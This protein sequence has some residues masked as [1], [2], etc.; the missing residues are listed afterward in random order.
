MH[1]QLPFPKIQRQ[2]PGHLLLL[3]SFL[4]HMHQPVLTES[5]KRHHV[6]HLLRQNSLKVAV[7]LTLRARFIK[8]LFRFTCRKLQRNVT[9]QSQIP[10]SILSQGTRRNR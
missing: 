5:K 9:L 8:R 1:M 6:Q 3:E 4:L 2:R 10:I 7:I